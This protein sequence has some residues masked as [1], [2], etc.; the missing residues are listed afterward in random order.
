MKNE[1]LTTERVSV[2]NQGM[3]KGIADTVNS[4]KDSHL[5]TKDDGQIRP[6][7]IGR[8]PGIGRI[9]LLHSRQNLGEGSIIA[10]PIERNRDCSNNLTINMDFD[11]P[12]GRVKISEED[13]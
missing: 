9:E 11:L 12:L 6:T 4:N 3:N 13:G 1:K 10:I 7:T 2:N 8:V 5:F